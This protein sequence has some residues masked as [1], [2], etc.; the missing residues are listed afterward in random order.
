MVARWPS[1]TEQVGRD[2]SFRDYF[3]GAVLVHRA[4]RRHAVS[5]A[6]R[7]EAA[8]TYR[9]SI[10]A[11]V[12]SSTG[13]LRGVLAGNVESDSALG[14]LVLHADGGD[15][16]PRDGVRRAMLVAL[17]DR[18]R[19][20]ET[21]VLPNDWVVLLDEAI[22]RPGEEVVVQSPVLDAIAEGGAAPTTHD[23]HTDPR[24]PGTW[25]AGFAPVPG[26]RWVVIVETREDAAVA[27]NASLAERVRRA[28][29][30]ASLLGLLVG[31]VSVALARGR[32][33]G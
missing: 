30:I 22:L 4:G 20:E 6:Y 19:S 10:S 15:E 3:Q 24:R 12:T 13:A 7:S 8:D 26:T 14:S 18:D 17:R 31:A 27:R 28:A 1:S 29:V 32:R 9:F 16:V 2:F 5:R 21:Q 23:A 11:P 25:L 33:W